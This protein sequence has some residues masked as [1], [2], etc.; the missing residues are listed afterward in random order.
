MANKKFDD[1]RTI[2]IIELYEVT[3]SNG[4]H[5]PLNYPRSF[6]VELN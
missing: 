5:S 4:F 3:D 2:Q 1:I 6:I